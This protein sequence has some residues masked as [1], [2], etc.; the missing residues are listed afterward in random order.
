MN[1][2]RDLQML[3]DGCHRCMKREPSFAM[4]AGGFGETDGQDCPAEK[5]EKTGRTPATERNRPRA[6]CC[7]HVHR[8]PLFAATRPRGDFHKARRAAPKR[9]TGLL[10]IVLCVASTGATL[11]GAACSSTGDFGRSNVDPTRNYAV[12]RASLEN[13]D[14]HF[15]LTDEEREMSARIHR[16]MAMPHVTP[17]L[18][19]SFLAGALIERGE[20]DPST[21]YAWIKSQR[22]SSSRGPYNRLH[23]DIR[24]DLASLPRVFSAICAVVE[25]DR[26]RNLALDRLVA[27]E[28]T[29]QAAAYERFSENR[30]RISQFSAA[31]GYRYDAYVYALEHL[32]VETPH[33]Q[34][35]DVDADLSKLA[36]ASGA[37]YSG[38]FCVQPR[39]FTTASGG[40]G[41]GAI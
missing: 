13:K 5:T 15:S 14:E 6:G 22:F 4:R 2:C 17:W 28:P 10:K 37:A 21:Y 16:F 33:E 12:T 31:L 40:V 32:L 23:N 9:M 38:S 26:R 30:E 25:I 8:R 36:T 11:L 20:V 29:V 34:A 41:L 39:T 27:V 1:K 7:R 35:R 3:R 18:H 19:N 24:L